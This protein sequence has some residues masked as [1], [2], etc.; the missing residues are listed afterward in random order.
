[1][2]IALTMVGPNKS[3]QMEVKGLVLGEILSSGKLPILWELRMAALARQTKQFLV[4][5][6]ARLAPRQIQA[7]AQLRHKVILAPLWSCW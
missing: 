5:V 2:V 4:V 7:L 6:V 1:M 3:M